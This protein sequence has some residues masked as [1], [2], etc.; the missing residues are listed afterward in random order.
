MGNRSVNRKDM[1]VLQ[2]EFP[3]SN[4]LEVCKILSAAQ[5]LCN[6]SFGM[7]LRLI[8]EGDSK[9]VVARLLFDSSGISSP[10]MLADMVFLA[11][12]KATGEKRIMYPILITNN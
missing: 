8:P 1:Y 3:G 11:I 6:Y 7:S 10:G 9:R 5:K 12:Q 2:M 4:R